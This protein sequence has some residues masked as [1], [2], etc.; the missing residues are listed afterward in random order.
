MACFDQTLRLDAMLGE[1]FNLLRRA[2]SG[3]Y[4]LHICKALWYHI[5]FSFR[6]S[7]DGA[8]RSQFHFF[9]FFF[10][11]IKFNLKIILCME[12]IH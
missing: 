11:F 10:F 9:F 12:F 8:Y 6:N 5:P 1:S 2:V 4:L 3:R 7:R